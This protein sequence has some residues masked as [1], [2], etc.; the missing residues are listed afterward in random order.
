M[1][2]RDPDVVR[3]LKNADTF[4]REIERAQIVR[5]L[6]CM[7]NTYAA[8]ECLLAQAKAFRTAAM[9]V[10]QGFHWNVRGELQVI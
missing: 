2:L 7:G 5:F 1:S 9:L 6:V 10:G 8:H 3:L 4:G